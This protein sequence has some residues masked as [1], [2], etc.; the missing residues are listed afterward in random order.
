MADKKAPP[1]EDLKT[2]PNTIRSID[3]SIHAVKS[4]PWN[5]PSNNPDKKKK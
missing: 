1:K 4:V 5:P 3:P 2:T